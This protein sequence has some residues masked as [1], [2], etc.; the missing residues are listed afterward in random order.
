M[1]L[2]DGKRLANGAHF[3]ALC[4]FKAGAGASSSMDVSQLL[5]LKDAEELRRRF[6]TVN[7]TGT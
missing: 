4:C 1:E 3:Y 5:A 6:A 7:A 2:K